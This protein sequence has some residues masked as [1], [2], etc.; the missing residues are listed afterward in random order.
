MST[1]TPVNTKQVQRRVLNYSS[2][3]EVLAE[4]E[5]AVAE[6]ATTQGNWS[7]AMIF[8]HLAKTIDCSLDGFGF[9]GPWFFKIAGPLLKKMF[10]GRGMPAGFQLSPE[11]TA[12]IGP[13]EADTQPA[14]DHLRESIRRF[15]ASDTVALH[16]FFGRMTYDEVELLHRRHCGLHMSFIDI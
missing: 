8:D 15:Q 13:T 5:R 1:A 3:D 6:D 16:P 11:A 9:Q 14:L 7:L 4:A 10:L 2:L 12:V